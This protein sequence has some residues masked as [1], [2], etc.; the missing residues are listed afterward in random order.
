V[1]GLDALSCAS[2]GN[3]AAGGSY[4]PSTA[5]THSQA[6]LAV[7]KSGHWGNAFEIAGSLNADGGAQL[8]AASCPA[9]GACVAGGYYENAAGH[10]ERFLI[11][12]HLG[13][14]G[15]AGKLPGLLTLNKGPDSQLYSLSCGSAGNCSGGGYYNNATFREFAFVST[16]SG[17]HWAA[18]KRVPGITSVSPGGATCPLPD[19]YSRPA[20]LPPMTGKFALSYPH[21]L[22]LRR[23]LLAGAAGVALALAPAAAS[24]SAGTPAPRTAGQYTTIDVPGAAGTIAVGANDAGVVSGFSFGAGGIEHGFLDRNGRF[25]TIDVPGAADTLVTVINDRGVVPGYY[26]DGGG[27]AHGFLDR[28][29]R[30]TTVNAPGAGPASGQG[31][32]LANVSD[33]GVIAG[34]FTDSGGV[35]HGFID[36]NG[37]FTIINDP[38]AGSGPGQGTS[39]GYV[40]DAGQIT[41][42][43]TQ[44][45]GDTVAFAGFPGRL[46]TVSDPA[47]PP[48]ATLAAAINDA[49]IV[50][51]EWADASGL[52]HGFTERHGVFTPVKD[53]AGAEGTNVEGI[54]NNGIIAG[55]YTDAG[56]VNHGFELTRTR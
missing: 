24:A 33:R 29:G 25:T 49:G 22:P 2:P 35:Q 10:L 52:F 15:K 23:P 30:I 41:G 3:C 27:A 1:A 21:L 14:W 19:C 5:S 48:F 47:A 56:A 32:F 38:H 51:G 18:A 4:R 11:S 39:V 37:R 45:N 40:N 55:F 17:G 6:W 43:Y 53:P 8:T 44:G 12:Q 34:F 26:L 7:Q 42:S 20:D 54:S 28:R 13:H 16:E 31:T 50:V 36:R 9:A 46:G